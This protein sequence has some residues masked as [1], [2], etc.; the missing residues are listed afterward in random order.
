MS[1]VSVKRGKVNEMSMEELIVEFEP[2]VIVLWVLSVFL[3]FPLGLFFLFFVKTRKLGV[4]FICFACCFFYVFLHDC[5]ANLEGRRPWVPTADILFPHLFGWGGFELG[6]VSVPFDSDNLEFDVQFSRRGRY[7]FGVWTSELLGNDFEIPEKMHI[8]CSFF[9]RNGV[10]RF[11]SREGRTAEKIWVQQ[12]RYGGSSNYYG[13]FS[14]PQ[15]LR[16]DEKYRAK[17]EF[18]G[19]VDAFRKRYP[20]LRFVIVKWPHL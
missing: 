7:G 13:I 20:N 16:Y 8:K 12:R 5:L 6:V 14:I 17:V 1:Y 2:L 4:G 15:D 11:A 18:S 10:M 19:D 3:F 9:D